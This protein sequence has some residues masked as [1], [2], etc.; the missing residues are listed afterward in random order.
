MSA[1]TGLSRIEEC[2][3]DAIWRVGATS[4]STHIKNRRFLDVMY[5]ENGIPPRAGFTALCDLARPYVSHLRLVD[6]HGNYGS[7]DF[8]PAAP[9]YTEARLTSLGDAASAAER[10]VGP[11]LPIGLVNG[12]THV[13]GTRPPLDPARVVRALCAAAD[14]ATDAEVITA[15]GPPAFPTGSMVEGDLDEL[16]AGRRTNLRLSGRI[17]VVHQ[18]DPSRG[19]ELLRIT[20]L[21]PEVGTSHVAQHLADH[22]E[23]ES[24]LERPHMVW[25]RRDR[26]PIRDVNDQSAGGTELLEVTLEPDVD[27]GAV[28]SAVLGIWDVH[29]VLEVD[30]GQPVVDILRGWVAEHGEH[31]LDAQLGP[32]LNVS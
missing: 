22:V 12:D 11:A 24:G 9:R 29:I 25:G 15:L 18:T 23:T 6:F 21:P 27:V 16:Y 2:V 3:L 8:G 31:D 7:R 30:F 19:G 20:N 14:G 13:D 32:I 4:S 1:A 26:L 17:E 10:G 5:A 28:V